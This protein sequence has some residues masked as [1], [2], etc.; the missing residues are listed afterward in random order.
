MGRGL[1]R[2]PEWPVTDNDMFV[3]WR[4]WSGDRAVISHESALSVHD[5]GDVNPSRIHLTVPRNFRAKDPAVV[6]HKQ[7]LPPTDVEDQ[8]DIRI[9]TVPRTLL[10]VAAAD[11]SQEQLDTAVADGLERGL[12]SPLKLR[13]RSDDHS[14]RAAL[15]IERALGSAGR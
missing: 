13:S 12:F 1:F 8:G 6:L 9:T 14:E 11:L 5:L 2:L 10:D 4:L 3:F 15:R 7:D